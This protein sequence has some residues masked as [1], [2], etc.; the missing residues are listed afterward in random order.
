MFTPIKTPPSVQALADKLQDQARLGAPL[1]Q[2][3]QDRAAAQ[4]ALE[5][6]RAERAVA[7]E[8]E[9]ADLAARIVKFTERNPAGAAAMAE[10]ILDEVAAKDPVRAVARRIEK[11]SR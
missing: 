2:P 7:T 6:H 10:A 4:H 11:A 9:N 3:F 5:K 8:R 1:R